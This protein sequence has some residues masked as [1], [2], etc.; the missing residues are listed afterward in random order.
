MDAQGPWLDFQEDAARQA[1]AAAPPVKAAPQGPWLDFQEQ[2]APKAAPV[3]G[4]RAVAQDDVPNPDAPFAE[5]VA[6]TDVPKVE[7]AAAPIKAGK[8][9]PVSTAEDMARAVP[10]GLVGAVQGTIGLPG[11]VANYLIDKPLRWAGGL[12][13]ADVAAQPKSPADMFSEGTPANKLNPGRA[14]DA[15]GDVVDKVT[16][17]IQYDPVTTAG[18]YTKTIMEMAPGAI[19][20]PETLI[21]RLI[22]N[23]FLPGVASET[24]GELTAGTKW[25]PW[26]RAGAAVGAGLGSALAGTKKAGDAIKE[27]FKNVEPQQIDNYM[28]AA[29]SLINDAKTRGVDITRAEALK[30]VSGGRVDLTNSQRLA[31]GSGKLGSYFAERPD[32]VKRA[33]GAEFD[34]VVPP[35]DRPELVGPAAGQ[36]AASAIADTKAGI[37]DASGINKVAGP[38]AVSSDIAGRPAV[39]AALNKAATATA[40][41]GAAV[42]MVTRD[43][44]G[45]VVPNDAADRF[46]EGSRQRVDT[47]LGKA[48]G[49]GGQLATADQI[50]AAR[51]AASDPLYTQARAQTIPDN[52]IPIELLSRLKA[53]GV[54]GEAKRLAGIAGEV[55]RI[56]TV[57]AWDNM[58]HALDDKIANAK[59]ALKPR[60]NEAR[61]LTGLKGD[62]TDALD[63]AVPAYAKAR[64]TFAG[65]SEMK[66]ALELGNSWA[67]PGVTREQVQREFAALKTPSE[68]AMARLGYGNA[69]RETLAKA[70]NNASMANAVA[71]N[72]VARAKM[73]AILPPDRHAELTRALAAEHKDFT[74]AL[75]PT[76][77]IWAKA[78]DILTDKAAGASGVE[79]EGLAS[80][81]SAV[82]QGIKASPD[83]DR[84]MNLQAELREQHLKPLLSGPI[85]KLQGQPE[86]KAAIE[87][88][89]GDTTPHGE[90]AV[91]D[92]VR[93]LSAKNP[94]AARQ[95]VRTY[96]EGVFNSATK[97]L[98]GAA[99]QWGGANFA[100][101][102]SEPQVAA[103][104]SAALQALP[105]GDTIAPGF[106]RFLEVMKA[107]GARQHIGSMTEFN[108][109]ALDQLQGG[110]PLRAAGT[111]VAG[112]LTKL[113][114]KLLEKFDQWRLGKNLDQ[115]SDL[116][117]NPEAGGLFRRLATEPQGSAKSIALAAR[118]TT[119]AGEGIRHRRGTD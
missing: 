89:F 86:T 112:G 42:P 25:E 113:P 71:G 53:A 116:L 33:A 54:S 75:Q 63:A 108:R 87:A 15:A 36:A 102:L 23:V 4:G 43:E 3:N 67:K 27:A 78:H 24:A 83:L 65:H 46:Q 97:D 39:E 68:Q 70:P 66:D 57:D 74:T 80:A 28:N 69:Q 10:A 73:A 19:G 18:K 41:E 93:A 29:D 12:T 95:L 94:W 88:L 51:K 49:D 85:G 55:P 104:F 13:D 84:A 107:T 96:A 98:Q 32:Q 59:S 44:T 30:T 52:A 92:A 82:R 99:N 61:L 118:L 8:A 101:A 40:N 2:D 48:F 37:A 105:N 38:V 100:K 26:A 56:D 11:A 110:A 45:A 103:N 91:G 14:L 76:P 114:G 62:L 16:K 79:G 64:A 90:T 58:K 34:T 20:A 106:G 31:E 117:V 6:T 35:T 17:P 1:P 72:D 60:P 9:A 5:R 115:L 50:I 119:L 77:G 81:A 7:T 111:L 22:K 109:R 21:P 47:A